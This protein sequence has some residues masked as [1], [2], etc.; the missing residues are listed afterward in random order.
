MRVAL[1]L[2]LML[3]LGAA[4]SVGAQEARE[5][6]HADAAPDPLALLFPH[7]TPPVPPV[8]SA[9]DG[10]GLV[11]VY[12]RPSDRPDNASAMTPTLR[13]LLNE[14]NGIVHAAGR[15]LD[16]RADLLARCDADGVPV[17]LVRHLATAASASSYDDI[18]GE[19][20]R[21]GLVDPL[22]KYLVYFDGRRADLGGEAFALDDE[23]SGPENVNEQGGTF[24]LSYGVADAALLLHEYAHSLGAVQTGAPHATGAHHCNDGRDV[25]CYA[26]GGPRASYQSHCTDGIHFDCGADDYFHPRP[27]EG[28]YLAAHWNLAS[29]R[30]LQ[31]GLEP[32]SNDLPWPAFLPRP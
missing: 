25:L 23:R 7:E 13:R 22:A 16:A 5:L 18:V 15:A 4:S 2:V 27:P 21:Q 31:V 11:L 29:S 28:S 3:L 19:L 10:P 30:W 17:V 12:A 8:C 9:P 24:A 26:D 14:S 1:V 32:V 6:R 20:R